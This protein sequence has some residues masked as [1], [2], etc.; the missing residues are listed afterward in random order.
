MSIDAGKAFADDECWAMIDEPSLFKYG[1][2]LYELLAQADMLVTDVSSVYVDFLVTQRPQI[3]YFPDMQRYEETRGLL[4]QPLEDFAPGPIV[5]AFPELLAQ[6]DMWIS[7]EDPWRGRRE[8]LRD[9]MIPA[10]TQCAADSLLAVLE[11]QGAAATRPALSAKQAA[12]E[13]QT[14]P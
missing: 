11:I 7:G 13:R 9:L 8:R 6:L 4:L 10:S 5:R 12:A 2:G 1:L 14:L 3:L